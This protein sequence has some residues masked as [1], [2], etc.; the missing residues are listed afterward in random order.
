ML[1]NPASTSNFR[2]ERRGK[3]RLQCNFP[4]IVR[5]RDPNTPRFEEPATLYNLSATGL[6]LQ[7][8]REIEQGTELF[9]CFQMSTAV[10]RQ[11]QAPALAIHGIVVRTEARSD[12]TCGL[13]LKLLRYHVL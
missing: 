6:Y 9:V 10:R 2:T 12:G 1:T 13:G 7:M 8:R 5:G 11:A 4:A 3:P